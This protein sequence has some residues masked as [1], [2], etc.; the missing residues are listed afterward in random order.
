[1]AKFLAAKDQIYLSTLTDID[2]SSCQTEGFVE[3]TVF[4]IGI[5]SA[6]YLYLLITIIVSK[7]KFSHT[8]LAN[9]PD[10]PRSLK[11]KLT[12]LIILIITFIMCGALSIF[13]EDY[14]TNTCGLPALGLI[15]LIPIIALVFQYSWL[16]Y[17]F[18]RKIPLLWF[19]NQLFWTLVSFCYLFTVISCYAISDNK[20]TGNARLSKPDFILLV[21]K[22]TLSTLMMIY[23]I[24]KPQD[25]AEYLSESG[26]RSGL[27]SGLIQRIVEPQ[28]VVVNQPKE[29]FGKDSGIKKKTKTSKLY[30]G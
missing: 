1:M 11:F 9:A 19:Q 26:L 22:T 13:Y 16:R 25:L 20:G 21:I 14:W 17:Q 6:F 7:C 12:L 28:R 18:E 29:K 15:Y 3:F 8:A 27:R 23:T 10:Y 4:D 24:R 30:A 5:I 2:Q